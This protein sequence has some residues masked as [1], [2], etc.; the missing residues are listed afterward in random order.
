MINLQVADGVAELTIQHEKV[1]N[2]FSIAMTQQL[3]ELCEAVESDDRVEGVLIW[4][5]EGRSFSVGG[6]FASIR[7][8]KTHEAA[9]SYLW[10]I[11]RSYQAILK[12]SKPVVAAIDSFVIG[13][14]LQVA[15]MADWRVASDRVHCQMPELKNGVPCPLGSRILETHLGR[16]A[17]MQLVI[18]CPELDAK[19]A[20]GYRLIDEVCPFAELKTA[21]LARLAT[22]RSYPTDPYRQTKRIHNARFVDQLEEVAEASAQAHAASFLKGTAEKHFS[23]VLGENP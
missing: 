21:A 14:G 9:T 20:M 18:G 10:D 16:A 13:Q 11:V 19:A 4:G 5:G 22:I 3:P 15:L 23:G 8:L 7:G 6:D 17:M 12:I 2:P 1:L